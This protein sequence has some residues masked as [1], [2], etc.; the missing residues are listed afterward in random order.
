VHKVILRAFAA[1]GRAPDPAALPSDDIGALLQELH[2]RDVVRLD[3]RGGIRAAYPFSA[4]STAHRVA[5]AD[6]PTVWAMC[7]IDALGIADMLERDVTIAS[8]DPDS[9]EP[10]RVTVCDGEARWDP[11]TAVVFDGAETAAGD[12]CRRR[13]GAAECVVAAADRSCG[14]MNFFTGTGSAEAWLAAHPRV[15]G[16]VLTKEQ[17]MR[18]SID[19]FGHLLDD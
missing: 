16:V 19:I 5:I 9:G 14:V 13:D 17:A 1:S 11:D 12:V 4:T 6:G 2:E 8:I 15:S 10:V 18:L 3:K 7:A